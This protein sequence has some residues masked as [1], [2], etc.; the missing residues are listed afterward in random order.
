ML[1]RLADSK[2]QDSSWIFASD[3]AACDKSRD[4]RIWGSKNR[5]LGALGRQ[6]GLRT[7]CQSLEARPCRAPTA[8]SFRQSMPFSA[9]SAVGWSGR[10]SQAL[11][12]VNSCARPQTAIQPAEA[13]LVSRHYGN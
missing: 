4:A 11:K 3:D 6:A 2:S 1:E 12:N 9:F 10:Y 7:A 8:A 13:L 5:L